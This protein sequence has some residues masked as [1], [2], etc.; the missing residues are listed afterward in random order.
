MWRINNSKKWSDLYQR[1]AWVRDLEGVVQSPVFHAE[2]DVAV[3]TQMVVE[4]LTALPAYQQLSEQAQEILFAAALLHDVEKRSTT[5]VEADGTITSRGHARKGAYTARQVLYRGVPAP[6]WIKEAVAKLVRYHGLPIWIFEKPEPEKALFKASLEVNTQWLSL[7]ARADMQG[8]ICPDQAELLERVEL[9]E[10]F[11]EEQGCWGQA[12]AFPSGL[13]QYQYFHKANAAP[14]Y[15][16]YEQDRF[17]V[18]LLSALPGTGKDHF[19]KNHYQDRPVISLDALRRKYRIAPTDRKG[20]GQMV[21]LAKEAAKQHLRRRQSFV[22]NATNI[23]RAIREPMIDLFQRYGAITTLVYI[24]VPY[25]QLLRQ[26]QQREYA[27]PAKVLERMVDRLE[28]P[29]L[30]E[31]PRVEWRTY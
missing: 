15:R 6:F 11:C 2:G 30:W 19:L 4:A 21:Q 17:E 23:T 24:E 22:W 5:V 25:E 28:V 9:F 26:N 31:A 13:G 29:A 16:P 8:R 12:R 18:V 1:F 3:H 7:L 20:N 27:I 14:D 10:A